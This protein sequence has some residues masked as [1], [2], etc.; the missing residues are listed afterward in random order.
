M[1]KQIAALSIF[2]LICEVKDSTY[3]IVGPNLI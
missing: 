3:L 1:N 2:V